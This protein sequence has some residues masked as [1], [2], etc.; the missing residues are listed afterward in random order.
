MDKAIFF[1]KDGVLNEDIGFSADITALKLYPETP[2][3][4]ARFA[5]LGYKI[6]VITNQAIVA[7]G[8]ETEAALKLFLEK[9]ELF[10]KEKN[11]AALITKIYYC[12]HHPNATVK[13]YKADCTCRKP[14]PGM[15]LSAAKE[16]NIDLTSSFMVGDRLSDIIAGHLAGCKTVLI[17]TGAH[18]APVGETN[19]KFDANIKPDFTINK[20]SKL[21]EIIK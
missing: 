4:I 12:P 18:T 11:P 19:F 20:L 3:I 10:I 14:S 7:K 17:E 1:D 13:E 21:M 8:L 6:F 2:D 16:F 9:F 5:G 15:L